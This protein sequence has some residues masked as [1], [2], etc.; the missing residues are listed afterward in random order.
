M[1]ERE[2]DVAQNLGV[3]ND[4]VLSCHHFTRHCRLSFP[5]VFLSYNNNMG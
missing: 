2:R 5:S 1:I 4:H 3:M